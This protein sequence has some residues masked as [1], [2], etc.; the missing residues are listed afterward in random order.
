MLLLEKAFL[1]ESLAYNYLILK[2]LEGVLK[3]ILFH[4]QFVS[5]HILNLIDLSET[6]LPNLLQHQIPTYDLF[7]SFLGS[8]FQ[9]CF[10]KHGLGNLLMFNR[11]FYYL[12]ACESIS[13][14]L[15]CRIAIAIGF[16]FLLKN[17]FA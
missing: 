12:V 6:T 11:T 10:S 3:A 15:V 13:S 16:E 2:A 1:E 4:C 14:I 8:L 17:I 9:K 5:M 7:R